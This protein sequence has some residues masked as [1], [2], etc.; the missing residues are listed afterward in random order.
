[1]GLAIDTRKGKKTLVLEEKAV[2]IFLKHTPEWELIF[3]KKR[4]GK[5]IIDGTG[6]NCETGEH[7][8][9]F[10]DKIRPHAR[11]DGGPPLTATTFFSAKNQHNPYGCGGAWMMGK[12]KIKRAAF[13]G[14]ELDLPLLG[15]LYLPASELLLVTK[16]ANRSNVILRVVDEQERITQDTIEGGTKKD[17]VIFVDMT[18]EARV[19]WFT[20]KTSGWEDMGVSP[21]R[22]LEY[23]E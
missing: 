2:E 10:E 20:E 7:N 13:V 16:I 14:Q 1:M 9:L 18:N 17:T 3:T 21:N 22:W 15:F 19:L 12:K 5:S 4:N 23:D 11:R 6:V 8:F